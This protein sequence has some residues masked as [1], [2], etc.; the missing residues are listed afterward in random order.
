LNKVKLLLEVIEAYPSI[1][2]VPVS[3]LHFVWD[4]R[5][6]SILHSFKAAVDGFIVEDVE[7]FLEEEAI[8]EVHS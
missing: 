7:E 8:T 6:G 2:F 1:D 4:S 5:T 3:H